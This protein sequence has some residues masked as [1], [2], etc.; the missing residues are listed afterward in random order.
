MDYEYLD[1][2]KAQ[3]FGLELEFTFIT[4]EQAMRVI[5]NVLHDED[6]IDSEGRQW[7]VKGDSS[8]SSKKKI[9]GIVYDAD[10]S[11]QCEMV[12][13]I[14]G[15]QD[16][17]LLQNIIRALKRAGADTSEKC[18]IHVH[19]SA[20][21]QTPQSLRNL[22]NL[23]IQKEELI[24]KAFQ[25][26]DDRLFRYCAKV[27]EGL[28]EAINK[29]T[30]NTVQ[31]LEDVWCVECGTR[32]KM[33]NLESLWDKKGIELRLFNSTFHAGLVRS[34]IVFSLALCCKAMNMSR[35]VPRRNKM[36]NERY[37]FRCWLNRLGL[38]GDE[39]LNCRKHLIKYLDG[40]S[41]FAQP[42]DHKRRRKIV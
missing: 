6:M 17:P 32:Y 27:E 37:E 1:N 12:T 15:Y 20:D 10:R 33:L 9:N 13:P 8:I 7:D 28:I 40:D 19:I 21:S 14:L 35:V 38:K 34:Y 29:N 36:T 4:R 18:G 31:E 24:I 16:I 23:M 42:E 26:P 5:V 41:A 3:E 22:L 2:M 25:I 39:F 11:Y 30:I